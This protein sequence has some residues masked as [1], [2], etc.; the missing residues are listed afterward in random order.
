M[1]QDVCR[2]LGF[3][4]L[5]HVRRRLRRGARGAIQSYWKRCGKVADPD[6]AIEAFAHDAQPTIHALFLSN[7][8]QCEVEHVVHI[9][10]GGRLLPGDQASFVNVF[11]KAT[12]VEVAL[13]LAACA[14]A[15][16]SSDP[17]ASIVQCDDGSVEF[18]AA[19]VICVNAGATRPADI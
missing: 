11:G 16:L 15:N 6:A 5:R 1:F 8:A 17:N 4:V 7:A 9:G 2:A 12:A 10:V 18:G 14:A 19:D 13:D 3:A